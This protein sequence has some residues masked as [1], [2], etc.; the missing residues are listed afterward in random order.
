MYSVSTYS[1][2]VLMLHHRNQQ[3]HARENRIPRSSPIETYRCP[4]FYGKVWF[5]D[6]L[7]SF[8][9]RI[10]RFLIHHTIT[11]VSRLI[12]DH[13][14]SFVRSVMGIPLFRLDKCMLARR[15][16]R[17]VRLSSHDSISPFYL[18]CDSFLFFSIS[19]SFWILPRFAVCAK[20]LLPVFRSK[21]LPCNVSRNLLHAISTP[22]N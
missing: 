13:R 8:R 15:R 16:E 20:L 3:L 12:P 7:S 22:A 14:D 5:F 19:P 1:V 18:R 4:I 10:P 11:P 17:K 21:A 9:P 2:D 6:F